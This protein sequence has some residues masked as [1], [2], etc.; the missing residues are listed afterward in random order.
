MAV[1]RESFAPFDELYCNMM[2]ATTISDLGRTVE[3]P[4]K[5]RGIPSLL[6]EL[7]QPIGHCMFIYLFAI[8]CRPQMVLHEGGKPNR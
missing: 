3:T 8:A 6:Q 2:D 1:T 4:P 7:R 5:R